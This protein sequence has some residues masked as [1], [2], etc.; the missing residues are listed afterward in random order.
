MA[1][2]KKSNLPKEN[3]ARVVALPNGRRPVGYEFVR[4]SLGLSAF[5]P[6]RPATIRPVSRVEQ[7]PEHLAVPGHV[8]PSGEDPLEHLLF[9]LKHEGTN[10]QVLAQ[11]LRRIPGQSLAA[12]LER[13]PMGGYI[14]V[15]A[16]LWELFNGLELPL[17]AN[18]GGSYTCVF[19]PERYVTGPTRRNSKWRVDFNGLG[20]L[21]MC[22]TV[23]RTDALRD[24]Q[25][26]DTLARTRT[27]LQEMP[28]QMVDRALAWAYLAETRGSYAI[29]REEPSQDRAEAIARLLKQA[30]EPREMDEEYLVELQNAAMTNAR[31]REMSFRSS[32]NWLQNGNMGRLG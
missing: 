4:Q 23:R 21:Q 25:A 3:M 24:L 30:H 16:H 10:L 11:A 1:F 8:A 18:F 32:Q 9:A 20:D 17:P 15:L 22:A 28:T 6:F 2:D 12:E 27:F 26:Q 5:E 13:T 29:E 14:R 19:D 31:A 7:E